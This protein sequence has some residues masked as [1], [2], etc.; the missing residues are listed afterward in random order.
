MCG[1]ARVQEVLDLQGT[2]RSCFSKTRWTI[3]KTLDDRF[4]TLKNKCLTRLRKENSK[5]KAIAAFEEDLEVEQALVEMR[6]IV[7]TV[8]KK[9]K[10]RSH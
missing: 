1:V 9:D 7:E 10:I 8:V 2:M 3:D 5:E 4:D 6:G